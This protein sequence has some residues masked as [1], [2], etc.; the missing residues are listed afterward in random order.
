MRV[1]A[2]KT[3]GGETRE[4]PPLWGEGRPVRPVLL[5]HGPDGC[6]SQNCTA[7]GDQ[8]PYNGVHLEIGSRQIVLPEEKK[9]S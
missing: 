3:F 5:K 4:M 7:K 8:D 9:R 6:A 2:G 1:S